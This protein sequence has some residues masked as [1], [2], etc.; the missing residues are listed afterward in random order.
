MSSYFFIFFLSF[1]PSVFSSFY[2]SEFKS[3]VR[4][5]LKMVEKLIEDGRKVNRMNHWLGA[6]SKGVQKR[7]QILTRNKY[8]T[9]F[10]LQLKS[11]MTQPSDKVWLI[12]HMPLDKKGFWETFVLRW[13]LHKAEWVY[14]YFQCWCIFL[15]EM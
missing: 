3:K 6:S 4:Q 14:N 8:F 12:P 11:Q 2:S 13:K 15:K 5:Y 7:P 9:I 10:M 1:F